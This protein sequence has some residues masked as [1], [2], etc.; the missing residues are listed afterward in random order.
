MHCNI[1]IGDVKIFF[2]ENLLN[3]MQDDAC[4]NVL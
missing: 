1:F 4:M 2:Y 3:I